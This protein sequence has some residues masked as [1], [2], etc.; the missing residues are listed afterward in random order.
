MKIKLLCFARHGL[1]KCGC[2]TQFFPIISVL[3]LRDINADL[4]EVTK[5]IHFVIVVVVG[6]YAYCKNTFSG[7]LP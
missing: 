7:G 3:L 1:R 4:V 6:F 5:S 2:L